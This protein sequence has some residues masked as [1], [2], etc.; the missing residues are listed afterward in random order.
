MVVPLIRRRQTSHKS[1]AVAKQGDNAHATPPIV[2][3][4]PSD[5]AA[6]SSP[7]RRGTVAPPF[8][9]AEIDRRQS[10]ASLLPLQLETLET[11][12]EQVSR[13]R[14]PRQQHPRLLPRPP[15][16]RPVTLLA[17][18]PSPGKHQQAEERLKLQSTRYR[19]KPSPESRKLSA[20]GLVFL[21]HPSLFRHPAAGPRLQPAS[22]GQAPRHGDPTCLPTW[23]INPP[24]RCP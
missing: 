13:A 8:E 4:A 3:V 2:I 7:R 22:I 24:P 10:L 21:S 23:S 6:Y 11:P 20:A 16:R 14:C 12:S 17:H 18:I 5:R 15:P 1:A 19:Y 9:T